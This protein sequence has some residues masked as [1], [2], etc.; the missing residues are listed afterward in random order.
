MV[1]NG[2]YCVKILG[3]QYEKGNVLSKKGYTWSIW[4]LALVLMLDHS[5]AFGWLLE[6]KRVR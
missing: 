2:M 5:A 4:L 1:G 6:G 3:L